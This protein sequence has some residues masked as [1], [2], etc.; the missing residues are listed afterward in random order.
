[1]IFFANKIS[2]KIQ[3]QIEGSIDEV[4]RIGF[5]YFTSPHKQTSLPPYMQAMEIIM[6]DRYN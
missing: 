6:D 4:V 2:R 3:D 5:I 1:M